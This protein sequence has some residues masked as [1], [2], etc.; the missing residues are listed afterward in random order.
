MSKG[1]ENE[2]QYQNSLVWLVEKATQ[3]EHPL[4]DGEARAKLDKQYD[5][6]SAKVREYN[7]RRGSELEEKR[8]VEELKKQPEPISEKE[9]INLSD[10]LDDDE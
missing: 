1:I 8:V 4:L 5:F 7:A 3:L 6:V 10:W 2:E 9:S